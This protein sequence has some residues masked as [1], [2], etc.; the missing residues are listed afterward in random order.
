MKALLAALL[1]AAGLAQAAPPT[2]SGNDEPRIDAL[3]AFARAYGVVRYFHPSDSLDRVDWS[4][5]VLA[6]AERMGNVADRAQLGSELE[7]LYTPIATGFKVAT[8]QTQAADIAGDGDRVEWRHLGYGMEPMPR[9]VPFV[10]WRTHHDPLNDGKVKGPYFQH[11]NE[12][13]APVH[14]HTTMHVELLPGLDA[15]VP[16]S[17]PM[18]ATKVDEAQA[19]RLKDLAASLPASDAE[20]ERL[21]R[22]QSW[23]DGIAA[24]NVARHFYP[25]WDATSVDWDQHLRRWLAAQPSEQTRAQLLDQLR[26]LIAPLDDGDGRILDPRDKSAKQ[27]LPISVRPLGER[28]VVDASLVPDRVKPGDVIAAV[29]DRPAKAYFDELLAMESGSPQFDRWRAARD[30]VVGPQGGKVALRLDRAGK[31]V[32]ASLAYDH[33][34]TVVMPRPASLSEVRPG[35]FYVDLSRFDRAA[36]EAAIP[37]LAAARGVIFDLRGYPTP[38]AAIVVP[39]WLTHPDSAQ[40]MMLPRFD[41]PFG[42]FRT[43]WSTGFNQEPNAALAKPVKVLLTDGRAAGYAESLI[44][45]FAGHKTGQIVGEA[46]GGENGNVI[47]ATLPSGMRYVFTGMRVMRHDGTLL[48]K[49]GFA[50]DVAVVP[51]VAGLRA[52]RD[53]VLERALT[54]VPAS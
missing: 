23:A 12:A 14:E 32:N 53:E 44:G 28:W 9:N 17:L 34:K 4:R 2:P 50:P 1:L 40:W 45:Y 22:A 19:A 31:A 26:R 43:G 33:A 13:Q 52:G 30:F 48:H 37:K 42:Q 25:Y 8:P 38:E 49:Q 15:L 3:V 47:A 54:L 21:T 46:T 41:K 16:V 29:N 6:G 5:F 35:V 20:A 36:F 7:A 18:S 24:W 51:S 27:Q 39:F 10:S 11:Q